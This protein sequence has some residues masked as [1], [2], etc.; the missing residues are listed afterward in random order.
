M[1]GTRTA[2]TRPSETGRSSSN[3]P[4]LE[5]GDHLTR[6]EFERR[7]DAMP[8]VKKAE[9]IEGVVSMPS[10]VR[11]E[12]HSEPH[13][14]VITWLGLYWVVTPGVRGGDNASLR[15]DMD[16]MP[17]PDAFL[18]ITPSS[19]GQVRI[20]ED[21]YLEGAPE[22]IVEI[23]SS[24]ASHDL[25]EKLHVY[26]R[27]GVREY[28]VWRVLEGAVSWFVLRDGR[29]ELL[30][31]GA[32]GLYRSEVLPGLWLDATALIQGD[33][34]ALV[35]AVQQGTATPEHAAFLQRLAGPV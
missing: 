19:G 24:S 21:D 6:L 9:L 13:F 23:A 5:N 12:K 28:V 35:R 15:L 2:R 7:Y 4:P 16:N 26:R 3:I 14:I 34:A 17:Q 33:R 30:E 18:F 31:P 1:S 10:P 27:N 11:Q 25:H 32:D 8:D 20:S 29:Y 22:M